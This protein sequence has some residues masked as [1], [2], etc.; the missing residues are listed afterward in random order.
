M[1]SVVA[2]VALFRPLSVTEGR[3]ADL[4]FLKN[5]LKGVQVVQLGEASH[6]TAEFSLMKVRLVRY[7]HEELGYNT[8]ALEAGTLEAGLAGLKRAD[9]SAPAL[10]ESVMFAGMH[11]KEMLSLFEYLK[12]KP[13]LKL[14]GL[15]PQ[16]SSNEVLTLAPQAVQDKTLADTFAKRLGE[17]YQYRNQPDQDQFRKQRDAYLAWLKGVGRDLSS[18]SSSP[19]VFV[20]KVGIE[21][22]IKYWNY[23]PG[24]PQMSLF[25]RRDEVLFDNLMAQAPNQKVIVW[26][27]NGHIGKGIGYKILG[28][29]L[30]EQYK[31]KTY[32]IGLFARSGHYK[33]HW[34]GQVNPWAP[35]ADGLESKF[36]KGDGAWFA[37]AAEL[38][39]NGTA[40]EPENGGVIPFNP[41]E[42]FNG[43]ILI[44]R[45]SPP[46]K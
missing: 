32:S 23:E 15:D 2:A 1:I 26:A 42:R 44:N 28:D 19:Q 30:V 46:T 45:V 27:H 14:I 9:L 20:L 31:Q 39:G 43:L 35:A 6:G 38:R 17:P 7:L 37:K 40:Y 12:S 3:L 10:M 24:T 29:F 8:L 36:P 5:E 41:A 11:G 21:G 13:K 33:Q 34:S 25:A 4:G 22:L 18:A 16:F